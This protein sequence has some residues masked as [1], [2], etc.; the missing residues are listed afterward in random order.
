MSD[1][2]STFLHAQ[3]ERAFAP[4]RLE[5]RDDSAKHAGHAGAK[6]GGNTHFHITIVS[7]AFTDKSR[8]QRHRMVYAALDQWMDDPI[9]ALQIDAK[10]SGEV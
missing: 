10:T 3:L 4:E 6:P 5:I 1:D 2:L 7:A 9:H 8:L